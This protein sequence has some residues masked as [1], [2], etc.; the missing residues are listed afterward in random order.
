MGNSSGSIIDRAYEVRSDLVE[1]VA[2]RYNF[3]DIRLVGQAAGIPI[4]YFVG[5][6]MTT[7]DLAESLFQVAEKK[8]K[9]GAVIN[10]LIIPGRNGADDVG[11]LLGIQVTQDSHA[12][13]ATLPGEGRIFLSHSSVD[14]PFVRSLRDRLTSEDYPC[15]VDE[16]EIKVGFSLRRSIENGIVTS[17]YFVIVLTPEA[18]ASEWVQRELDV[19]LVREIRQKNV[20]ILPILLRDCTIHPMLAVKKYADFRGD[21]EKGYAELLEALQ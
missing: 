3:A 2:F 10:Q 21:F 18:V 4:A 5:E 8:G 7:F 19:A 14:K 9:F 17:G 16:V 12:A 1:L 20:F 13:K 6:K 11:K 15:W